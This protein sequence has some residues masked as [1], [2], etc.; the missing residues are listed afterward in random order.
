MMFLCH[1]ACT[2]PSKACCCRS[3]SHCPVIS[4]AQATTQSLL[5]H[6]QNGADQRNW[7]VSAYERKKEKE[8]GGRE[9]TW[10]WPCQW[11]RDRKKK[12]EDEECHLCCSPRNASP[13][14]HFRLLSA[15]LGLT[16]NDM[17]AQH[18]SW[19][20]FV[21]HHHNCIETHFLCLIDMNASTQRTH[22]S[23]AR[24]T[25]SNCSFISS[26]RE[27]PFNVESS[28]FFTCWMLWFCG[29]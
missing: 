1:H 10:L 21:F 9:C 14:C 26:S 22:I 16:N 5:S 17:P 25:H 29:I 24:L 18:H 23:S 27:I 13:T 7:R 11:E 12:E 6:M 2:A 8:A 3:L 15:N 20:V 4:C 28:F 19:L